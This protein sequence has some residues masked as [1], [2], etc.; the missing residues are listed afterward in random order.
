MKDHTYTRL[1][2]L[3]IGHAHI[4][5]GRGILDEWSAECGIGRSTLSRRMRHPE[6]I[7]L[8]ELRQMVRPL[9]IRDEELR[10][11]LPL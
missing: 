5:Y 3:L 9:G 7:S 6:D 8:G 4:R 1:T 10:R 2:A 11:V